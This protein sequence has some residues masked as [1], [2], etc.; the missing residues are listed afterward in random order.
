MKENIL[1]SAGMF[2]VDCIN[3]KDRKPSDAPLS[4]SESKP[5]IEVLKDNN[6]KDIDNVLCHV[7][8]ALNNPLAWKLWEA[9][10]DVCAEYDIK[11]IYMFKTC[12]YIVDSTRLNA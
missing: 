10:V 11:L 5:L 6:V 9:A 2:M 4:F 7:N 3:Y 1:K 12:K 8:K